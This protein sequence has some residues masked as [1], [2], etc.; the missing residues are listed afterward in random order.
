MNQPSDFANKL[1]TRHIGSQIYYN[2][3]LLW[4]GRRCCYELFN[5]G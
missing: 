3:L 2:L 5:I 4:S 1:L